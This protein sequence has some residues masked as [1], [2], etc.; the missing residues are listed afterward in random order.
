MVVKEF[1][2][3]VT[4]HAFSEA[5]AILFGNYAR[6]EHAVIILPDVVP[7][8]HPE[9]NKNLKREFIDYET[10]MI[11]NEELLRDLVFY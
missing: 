1:D 11:I 6:P 7:I 10:S 2:V 8:S 5:H 4:R 9:P 3:P